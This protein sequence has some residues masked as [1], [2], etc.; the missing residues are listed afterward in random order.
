M[1]MKKNPSI[2]LIEEGKNT[3]NLYQNIFKRLNIENVTRI[4][5]LLDILSA[6]KNSNPDIIIIDVSGPDLKRV[7]TIIDEIEKIDNKIP[8]IT[9]SVT[10]DYEIKRRLRS[11]PNSESFVKPLD[12]IQF[13]G[14]IYK[15]LSG[16]SQSQL[17]SIEF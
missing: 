4:N 10:L 7:L 17:V 12:I 6:V 13:S 8:I 14:S 3:S 16:K 11:N 15:L 5:N 2:L 1:I 9:V